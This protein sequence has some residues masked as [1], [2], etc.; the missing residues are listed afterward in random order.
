MSTWRMPGAHAYQCRQRV[1]ASAVP[2]VSVP[3]NR[4]GRAGARV[5]LPPLAGVARGS[6]F[7]TLDAESGIY[8]M[9]LAFRK[10]RSSA[11]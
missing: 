6:G 7:Q 3:A 1:V 5:A 4:V 8:T 9:P 2:I 11:G 10:A